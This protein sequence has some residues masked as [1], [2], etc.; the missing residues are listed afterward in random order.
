MAGIVCIV[1]QPVLAQE[2][3]QD[4]VM[5][6]FYQQL[7]AQAPYFN[8]PTAGAPQAYQPQPVYASARTEQPLFGAA[9]GGAP[10]APLWGYV[11]ELRFGVLSH[12][13]KFPSRHKMHMPNPF[14]NRYEGGVNLNPEVVFVSPDFL[15][16]IYAPRLHL[17]ATLNT[18]GDTSSLY[19]GLNWDTIWDNGVFLEGFWGLAVHNG[20]LR[21]GNPDKIE[22]GSQVVFRLG[23]ETGW[24]WDDNNGVSLIWEHMSH[25]DM[26]STKN[27]GIDSLGL[28]Y[29]YRFDK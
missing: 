21:G 4:P 7:Q 23:G 1:S 2:V 8:T 9:T 25:A 18:A 12:D 19:G 14:A 17:G 16:L 28:R 20:N 29:S 22:F 15:E 27:Q 6:L 5:R 24:R 10:L 3:P 26:F 13:I 11:S